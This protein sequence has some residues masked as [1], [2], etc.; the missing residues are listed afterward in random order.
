MEGLSAGEG[1]GGRRAGLTLGTIG[2]HCKV[3][4]RFV[5]GRSLLR[6]GWVGATEARRL[7]RRL[8]PRSWRDMM[9]AWPRSGADVTETSEKAGTQQGRPQE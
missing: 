6:E 5:L 7:I 8:L 3:T 2:H 1:A 4:I 9:V